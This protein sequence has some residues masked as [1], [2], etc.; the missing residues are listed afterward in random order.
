MT[1][2]IAGPALGALV[3]GLLTAPGA[4]AQTLDDGKGSLLDV[5]KTIAGVGIGLDTDKQPD[6]DYRD[7]PPLVLPKDRK[8]L[9]P[10]IARQRG[11]AWPD[12]PDSAARREAARRAPRRMEPDKGPELTAHQLREGRA[13][14]VPT[15][16]PHRE[17]GCW[18]YDGSECI[19]YDPRR[20]RSMGVLKEEA[21]KTMVGS[22]PDRN[23]LVQPPKGYRRVTQATGTGGIKPKR[24][25]EDSPNPLG[26]IK[27]PFQR[28]EDE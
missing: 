8:Q 21:P 16:G 27:N 9:A 4:F 18:R 24:P 22:E 17:E 23:W 15:G 6:I 7:R 10:P 28:D 3:I 13:S 19:Q 12:D 25:D 1:A 14:G 11:A 5:A 26:F 2:R 20:L